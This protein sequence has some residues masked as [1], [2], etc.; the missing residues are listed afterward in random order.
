[1]TNS[2]RVLDSLFDFVIV[3]RLNLAVGIPDKMMYMLGDAIAFN[4]IMAL[5]HMAGVITVSRMCPPKMESTVYAIISG[6]SNLGWNL[7]KL[8]GA[9][10]IEAS[11]ISTVETAEGGC[12]FENL[13][14]LILFSHFFLP[15]LSIPLAY[16]MLPSEPL[17]AHSA[18]PSPPHCELRTVK[19]MRVL[20]VST[21]GDDED[22][23]I[24]GTP[25]ES[26]SASATCP[27]TSFSGGSSSRGLADGHPAAPCAELEFETE[28]DSSGD[29]SSS[30]SSTSRRNNRQVAS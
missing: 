2:I 22:E 23:Q 27:S 9:R 3:R 20:P 16:I 25:N 21:G 11:G 19:G 14:A 12:N 6:I 29:T 18:A 8:M 13:P 30:S 24:E 10:A 15:L 7:S 1:M 5:N 28:H 26:H 17:D 4:V